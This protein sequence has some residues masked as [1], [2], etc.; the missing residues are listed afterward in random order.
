MKYIKSILIALI[1]MISLSSVF[2]EDN[3]AAV[4]TRL[5]ID[6]RSI[7]MG[8]TGGAFLDNVSSTYLNP[9]VL[10]DVKRIELT[11]STRQNMEWD[12]GHNAVALGFMLPIGY[13]AAFWQ[14]A[15]V[16]DID[17]YNDLG[18]PTSAFDA[19]DNAFGI[20]YAVKISRLNLGVTPKLY[21]SKIE[22]ESTTGYGVDLGA[23]YH[24][25]RYFNLGMAVRDVV[26]DYDGEG[27][28]VPREFIPSIAAFPL[29]GLILAADLSGEDDFASSKLKLGAEYWLGVRDDNEIGSSLSGIRIRENATWTDILSK[30]QAGVRAGINDGAFSAGFGLRFKMLEMNYAYQMAKESYQNDNHLYSLLLR[31]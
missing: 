16:S 2:A 3:S 20:S 12:K 4:Y 6:A 18:N 29:P 23:L 8:G 17:G 13:V 28:E 14:N 24:L 19:A 26:S 10:A 25:N 7:G 27:T 1:L 30:T 22:D 5:G 11:T 9:A 21:L 31:F 15:T